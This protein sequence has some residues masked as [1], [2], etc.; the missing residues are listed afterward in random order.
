MSR[1]ARRTCHRPA[2]HLNISFFG[3]T[4]F[5]AQQYNARLLYY[6]SFSNE[7]ESIMNTPLHDLIE[8]LFAAIEAKDL[9]TFLQCIAEDAVFIDPH[10]PSPV[11]NGKVAITDGI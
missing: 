1:A 4:F 8:R 6:L 3:G 9:D 5:I 10:Y 11:M 2:S 7:R